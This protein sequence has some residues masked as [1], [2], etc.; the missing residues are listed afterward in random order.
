MRRLPARLANRGKRL[1]KSRKA[2]VRDSSVVHP[3]L[4]IE[5]KE[6]LPSQ[7]DPGASREGLAIE[8]LL[9]CAAGHVQAHFYAPAV[10][11]K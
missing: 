11:L 4:D 1:V 10:A 3:L 9:A 6:T 8:N 5:S 2:Y 7:P